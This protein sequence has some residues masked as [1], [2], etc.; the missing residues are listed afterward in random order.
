[1]D[2]D[3]SRLQGLLGLREGDDFDAK[4]AVYGN[5]EADKR[6][7]CADIAA[8]ANGRGGVIVIGAVEAGETVVGL[9]PVPVTGE[10]LRVRQIASNGITPPVAIGVHTIETDGD[11]GY[12]LVVVPPSAQAPHAVVK[13]SD[14]RYPVR[15]G[16]RKRYMRESE[17]SDRYRNRFLTAASQIE[18]LGVVRQS[19]ERLIDTTQEVAWLVVSSVPDTP[20][21]IPVSMSERRTTEQWIRQQSVQVPRGDDFASMSSGVTSGFRRYRAT[22]RSPGSMGLAIRAAAEFHIDGS[23]GLARAVGW[24]WER[25]RSG[26]AEQVF[27]IS[28]TVLAQIVLGSLLVVGSHAE[29]AGT[30]GTA[31]VFASIASSRAVS[32]GHLRFHGHPEQIGR[33]MAVGELEYGAHTLD[34]DELNHPGP[35]LVAAAALVTSDLVATL[36]M[37]ECLQL[38]LE[39]T[40]RRPYVDQQYRQE[41][42]GWAEQWGIKVTDE[43]VS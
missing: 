12:L 6:E 40:I 4:S 8:F 5:G 41:L 1:V 33:P 17:V 26:G 21:H 43:Q 38:S 15:D 7:L 29:R 10:E 18:R 28:D 25:A 37:A 16:A 14:L 34:L 36:G 42:L 3:V 19:I 9:E 23:V 31:T 30:A 35:A 13:D 11:L 24:D 2:V 32:L 20:G 27:T 39:G 22:D